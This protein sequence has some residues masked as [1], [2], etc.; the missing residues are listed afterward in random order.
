MMYIIHGEIRTKIHT[1]I[2]LVNESTDNL[3]IICEQMQSTQLSTV[4]TSNRLNISTSSV[5]LPMLP[6]ST[7]YA[8]PRNMFQKSGH[9]VQE[10]EFPKEKFIFYN[11]YECGYK[12]SE[13]PRCFACLH[14][15]NLWEG[16]YSIKNSTFISHVSG[17]SRV[18][19]IGKGVPDPNVASG[20]S[21]AR[22]L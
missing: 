10:N 1:S 2:Q 9:E 19:Q 22:T 4:Q 14:G 16:L 17:A 13:F 20:Y 12:V 5:P 3:P 18:S 6:V 8:E 7:E 15:F 21:L 11:R